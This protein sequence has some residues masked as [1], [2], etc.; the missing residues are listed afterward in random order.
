MSV[1]IFSLYDKLL[2]KYK[3]GLTSQ[4]D[5]A[6]NLVLLNI[7]TGNIISEYFCTNIKQ[8]IEKINEHSSGLSNSLEDME[9]FICLIIFLDKGNYRF[10]YP[11][12]K[13]YISFSGVE[14][15]NKPELGDYDINTGSYY[16]FINFN[17][18]AK[19]L[20]QSI[21]YTFMTQIDKTGSYFS[22][23]SKLLNCSHLSD[24]EKININYKLLKQECSANPTSTTCIDYYKNKIN[25]KPSAERNTYYGNMPNKLTNY[26]FGNLNYLDYYSTER[27]KQYPSYS[28]WIDFNNCPT[29][30]GKGTRGRTRIETNILPMQL[31][32]SNILRKEEVNCDINCDNNTL[33]GH[34]WTKAAECKIQTVPDSFKKE[35]SNISTI[36]VDGTGGDSDIETYK[37]N[38]NMSKW[39]LGTDSKSGI[40]CYG[41]TFGANYSFKKKVK[42]YSANGDT[43]MWYSDKT[44]EIVYNGVKVYTTSTTGTYTSMTFNNSTWTTGNSAGYPNL[45]KYQLFLLSSDNKTGEVNLTSE[46]FRNTTLTIQEG[47]LECSESSVIMWYLGSPLIW[48]NNLR[49]TAPFIY[50]S[51]YSKDVSNNCKVYNAAKTKYIRVHVNGDIS[52]YNSNNSVITTYAGTNYSKVYTVSTPK[53]SYSEQS[54]KDILFLDNKLYI[55]LASSTN[56][57]GANRDIGAV[58]SAFTIFLSASAFENKSKETITD[59]VINYINFVFL[60][61]LITIAVI[62]SYFIFK[63]NKYVKENII[64]KSI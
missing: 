45:A 50:S 2:N 10:N 39:T 26:F 8:S 27:Q 47:R 57:S 25:Y 9:I 34:A 21:N 17:K 36:G 58:N 63:K 60:I 31:G 55:K 37:A 19:D 20:L 41:S 53:G 35:F 40:E 44:F 59:I 30:C 46:Y 54:V 1:N 5:T 33:W 4:P 61:I 56:T 38:L 12:G 24:S 3:C 29:K 64:N 49:I 22:I 42:Y 18:I 6:Q 43:Y 52:I 11:N 48:R 15:V 16:V 14:I 51:T 62:I 28:S 32:K 23:D 13:L 7:K